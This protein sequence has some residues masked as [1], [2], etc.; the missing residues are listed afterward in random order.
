[1]LGIFLGVGSQLDPLW[2]ATTQMP[3]LTNAWEI[4]HLCILDKDTNGVII[5]ANTQFVATLQASFPEIK[6]VA[7]VIG[8]DDFYFYPTN[9]AVKYRADD[10]AVIQGG[11]F[12]ETIEQN[13]PQG[14]AATY[15]Y[16]SKTPLR[17]ANEQVMAL[18]IQ[19]YGIPPPNQTTLPEFT[20]AWDLANIV[21]IDKDTNSVFINANE[22]FLKTLR[23]SFPVIQTITNLIGRD[24][25]YIYSPAM[26]EKFRG[27]DAQVMASGQTFVDNEANEPVGGTRTY[28]HV[29][30]TPLRN[31]AGQIFGL[32]IEAF[33]LP[34]LRAQ[35]AGA[36]VGLIWDGD[37][38][39]FYLEQSASLGASASWQRINPPLQLTNAEV[40]AR[41]AATN[42]A[43]FFRLVKE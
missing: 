42:G 20:N 43:S 9:L 14:G 24:D 7:D 40:R 8:K 3:V 1:L 38:T 4:A 35:S 5:N 36:D 17:D 27:D 16:V 29:T 28:V 12:W 2:A 39:G 23:P 18:R 15:V 41:I 34:S 32:H 30:K 37:G 31:S 13:Q 10:Q 25:Y 6:T 22:N 21:V 11:V 33:A 26:A 19:F